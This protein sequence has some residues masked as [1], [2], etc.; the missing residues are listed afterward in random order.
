VSLG[1]GKPNER[2][3]TVENPHVKEPKGEKLKKGMQLR[4]KSS[5]FKFSF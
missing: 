3:E 5:V 4:K 2:R 1:T